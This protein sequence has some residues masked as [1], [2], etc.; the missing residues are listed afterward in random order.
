MELTLEYLVPARATAL[1]N[2]GEW[3]SKAFSK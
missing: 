2:I 1:S 3:N